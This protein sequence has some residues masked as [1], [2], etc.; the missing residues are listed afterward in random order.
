MSSLSRIPRRGLRRQ[1]GFTLIETMIALGIM[2][3]A[4]AA[5]LYYQTRAENNQ[6]SNKTAQD[7]SL[8][9]SKIKN[10]L[11]PSNSYIPLTPVFVNSSAL[12]TPPM[13]WDGTNV[14][15][16]WGNTMTINGGTT[17]FALTIGGTTSALDKE[18]C[19]SIASKMV[20]N[21]TAINIGAATAAAGVVSGGSAY[22][23]A[24]G[25][26]NGTNL[27]T[28]CAVAN[29]VIAVQFR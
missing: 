20:D 26:P 8:M 27:A 19:T 7:L 4:V 11:G 12:I 23:A 28:G 6:G 5:L 2:G 25:T 21:A 10:Y 24:N 13:K 9:A 18:V 1:L 14:L 16:P 22:K 29:P 15:D 3:T 17:T